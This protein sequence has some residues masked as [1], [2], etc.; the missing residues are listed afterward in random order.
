MT[1]TQTGQITLAGIDNNANGD[2]F[3]I[4][5]D[6]IF[7]RDRGDNYISN[8]VGNRNAIYGKNA[9]SKIKNVSDNVMLGF[10]SGY[11]TY[12]STNLSSKGSDNTFIGSRAGSDNTTGEKNIYIGARNSYNVMRRSTTKENVS[13]RI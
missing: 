1:I 7:A 13:I 3:F 8:Y 11:Y 10:E 12:S 6:S 4:S 2:V 5:R 9:G